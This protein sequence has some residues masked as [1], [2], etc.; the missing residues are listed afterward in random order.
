MCI[1][2]CR[3]SCVGFPLAWLGSGKPCD[4]S[5]ATICGTCRPCAL[6]LLLCWMCADFI[7]RCGSMQ[8]VD[9][10][11]HRVALTTSC[12]PQIVCALLPIHCCIC[13][14][15]MTTPGLLVRCICD[16][17]MAQQSHPFSIVRSI[18]CSFR[19]EFV[20]SL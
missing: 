7:A 10:L 9:M 4:N 3:G 16:L 1:V 6:L 15:I 8:R 20:T 17:F 2:A 13:G 19:A 5:M 12:K 11:V 18:P 14:D